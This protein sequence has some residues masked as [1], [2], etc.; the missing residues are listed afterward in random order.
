MAVGD[1]DGDGDP[2][3]VTAGNSGP[4]GGRVVTRLNERGW[5][6]AAPRETAVATLGISE[7]DL[8]DSITTASSTW[9][10]RAAPSTGKTGTT[11]R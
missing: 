3:I 1:V 8:G 4:S 9:S 10:S 6:L 5:I 2:D 7:S 11:S